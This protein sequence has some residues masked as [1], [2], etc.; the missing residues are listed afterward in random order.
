MTVREIAKMYKCRNQEN[1]RAG[2]K[3]QETERGAGAKK[4]SNRE[5]LTPKS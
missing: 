3:I 1:L 2:E 5:N 4:E